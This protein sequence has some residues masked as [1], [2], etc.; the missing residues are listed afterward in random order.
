MKAFTKSELK[1]VGIIF[2]FLI[3]ITLLNLN[4]AVRRSRDV[5]RRADLG[6]IANALE[7]YNED[8][9]YFPPVSDG[10]LKACPG[11]NFEEVVADI[12]DDDVFQ[13]QKL[14]EGLRACSWGEDGLRDLFDQDYEPY[15]KIIP[16][17]PS[18][19]DGISYLYISNENLFQIL[20]YL[21]GEE[22]ED[23]YNPGIV[24][25]GLQCGDKICNFGK[26]YKDIPLDKSLEEYEAEVAEKRKTGI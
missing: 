13:R 4:I 7:I 15:L 19:D 20:A 10:K 26:S 18:E 12:K 2:F 11:E 17:D 3:V 8:F 14:F 16:Q 23:G 25:R 6:A 24:A 9:G 21:E 22:S 1:G 5:Q